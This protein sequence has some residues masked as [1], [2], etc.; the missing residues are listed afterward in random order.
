MT[1]KTCF[2]RLLIERVNLENYFDQL[3]NLEVMTE[4]MFAEMICQIMDFVYLK[5]ISNNFK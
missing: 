2:L 3:D 1:L 4:T 5:L